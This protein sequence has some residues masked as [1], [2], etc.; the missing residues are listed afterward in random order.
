M[1][2][3]IYYIIFSNILWYFSYTR[4]FPI[5]YI[6]FSIYYDISHILWYSPYTM[7]FPNILWYFHILWYFPEALAWSLVCDAAN[8]IRLSITMEYYEMLAIYACKLYLYGGDSCIRPPACLHYCL[9]R[10]KQIDSC[11]GMPRLSI[12]V[13]YSL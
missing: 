10:C 8:T 4:T 2:F 6:I 9:R 11:P 1:T 13:V 7:I 3:P 5:Y 12:Q